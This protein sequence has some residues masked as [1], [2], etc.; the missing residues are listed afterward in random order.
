[1]SGCPVCSPY[2]G[3]LMTGQYPHK[4]GV[5]V[6]DVPFENGATSF[7]QALNAAGYATGYIGKWHID[8]H[9]RSTYIPRER[10]QGFDFWRVLECTHDYNNSFYYGDSEEKLK[11]DGYDAIAQ[12]R[13]AERYIRARDTQKPF[14]LFLSWGPPHDPYETAPTEYRAMYD[15][16]QLL[17]RPNVPRDFEATSRKI[18]AG[19]Y[20]HCSVLSTRARR[21]VENN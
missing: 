17:L 13:E 11:W 12:T 4:H 21:F 9:G 14:A 15:T 6:N 10:R 19:Y 20:A 5:F 8:G 7:A 2:R 1:M 16:E 18:G 3:T